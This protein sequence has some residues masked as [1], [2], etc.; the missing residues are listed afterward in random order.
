[1][2]LETRMIPH[3]IET[4]II[5][6]NYMT[7]LISL[8]SMLIV[9]MLHIE[10]LF[11]YN[12][13]LWSLSIKLEHVC[14]LICFAHDLALPAIFEYDKQILISLYVTRIS[15]L[16]FILNLMPIY[17]VIDQYSC[18]IETYFNFLLF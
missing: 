4:I 7:L 5:Y 9:E 13:E 17:N 16:H 14:T 18:G 2:H 15:C 1:M 12:L 6:M 3:F 8:V 10:Q 11:L